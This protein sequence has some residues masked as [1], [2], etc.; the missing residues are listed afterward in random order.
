MYETLRGPAGQKIIWG[1]LILG[2][3]QAALLAAFDFDEDEPPDFVKER[4]IVIPTGG[5]KY[6]TVPMPLGYNVIP[7]TSRILTE[8]TMSGFKD[9]HKRVAQITGQRLICST[10]LETQAGRFKHLPPR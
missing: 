1:G 6:I 10:R 8:W 7:N 9:T 5:G 2:S 4:N 3:A